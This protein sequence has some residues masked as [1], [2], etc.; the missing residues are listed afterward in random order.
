[1]V[2]RCSLNCVA[3]HLL[4]GLRNGI[5]HDGDPDCVDANSD[6]TFFFFLTAALC[7]CWEVPRYTHCSPMELCVIMHIHSFIHVRILSS[8][9]TTHILSAYTLQTWP[10]SLWDE[11]ISAACVLSRGFSSLCKHSL[12][13][14]RVPQSKNHTWMHIHGA[15]V[16]VYICDF[17][18]LFLHNYHWFWE[19][20]VVG[21]CVCVC[22]CVAHPV[23][24]GGVVVSIKKFAC[25]DLE[26]RFTR[27]HTH[28]HTHTKMPPPR[29]TVA[30]G[31]PRSKWVTCTTGFCFLMN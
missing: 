28:T 31:L 4:V 6:V 18:Y 2:T 26:P 17:I 27:L 1:M 29:L 16:D 20:N 21:V 13:L 11:C 9:N 14:C 7:S 30:S 23:R 5:K 3:M 22:V 25:P 24:S 19:Q 10:R 15:T 12:E 8:L